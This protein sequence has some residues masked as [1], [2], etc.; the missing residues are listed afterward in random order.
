MIGDKRKYLSC[1][2]T[3]KCK[4][5]EETGMPT[6]ELEEKAVKWCDD[7]APGMFRFFNFR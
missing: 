3:L 7:N 4:V 6:N 1:L 5:D 2:I